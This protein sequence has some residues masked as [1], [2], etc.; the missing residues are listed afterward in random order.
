MT[1][2]DRARG[3]H[4]R[5]Q[6]RRLGDGRTAPAAAT[7]SPTSDVIVVIFHDHGT[8]YLGKMFNDDWMREKGFIEKHGMTRA[9]SGGDA[10]VRRAVLARSKEPVEHAVP[11]DERARL[12]ADLGHA[13]QPPLAAAGSLNFVAPDDISWCWSSSRRGRSSVQRSAFPPSSSST[14]RS[15]RAAPTMFVKA[16]E[17]GRQLTRPELYARA[18]ARGHLNRQQTRPAHPLAARAA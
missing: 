3:R 14:R 2:P 10:A 8:R 17:G 12:L 7:T 11:A 4:L 15:S 13:R 5:R 6:L 1:R 18:R 16:L 9:R